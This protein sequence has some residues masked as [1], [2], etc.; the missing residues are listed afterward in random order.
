MDS[1]CVIEDTVGEHEES[2]WGYCSN[3]GGNVRQQRCGTELQEIEESSKDFLPDH[4]C[5]ETLV[6]GARESEGVRGCMGTAESG[7]EAVMEHLGKGS[8]QPWEHR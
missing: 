5:K 6:R 7:P 8:G 4:K 2:V 3:S 1:T